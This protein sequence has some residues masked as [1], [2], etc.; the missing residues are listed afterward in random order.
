M[1]ILSG[2]LTLPLAPIRGTVWVA[3]QV[4]DEAEREFYDPAV[5]RRQ[6][7]QIAEARR[8]GTIEEHDADAAERE[9]VR[10]LIR[11]HRNEGG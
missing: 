7:D 8:E 11:S 4:R 2:L 6:L 5:I 9:L 1:G 3:E 10:R